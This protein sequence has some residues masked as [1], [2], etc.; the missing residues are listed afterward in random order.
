MPVLR[1]G[2]GAQ[3]DSAR[4][5]GAFFADDC[6]D[7][8]FAN[9]QIG[10][11]IDAGFGAKDNQACFVD[12]LFLRRHFVNQTF[13][14]LLLRR[15][16]AVGTVEHEE[17]VHALEGTQPLEAGDSEDDSDDEDGANHQREPT[18]PK[19]HLHIALPGK[20]EHP[21]QR[22]NQQ[23]QVIRLGEL[24]VH[25]RMNFWTRWFFQSATKRSSL[26]SI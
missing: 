10:H 13:G 23:Q 25:F 16:N 9:R 20:P 12:R 15:R 18:P 24:E 22:R 26:A 2:G 3:P 7:L 8:L 1:K 4:Q 11:A 6:F 21:R 19:A 5:I 17:Y 14:G